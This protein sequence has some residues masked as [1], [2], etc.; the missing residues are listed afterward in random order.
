MTPNEIE[1][2]RAHGRAPRLPMPEHKDARTYSVGLVLP[3]LRAEDREDAA[4]AFAQAMREWLAGDIDTLCLDVT[5]EDNSYHM[6][7]YR[8][9]DL[10]P[11]RED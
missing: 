6:V 9:A 3:S 11:V 7:D 8:A 5:D 2:Q 10:P 4:R 1:N